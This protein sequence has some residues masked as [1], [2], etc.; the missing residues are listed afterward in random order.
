M[1]NSIYKIILGASASLLLC[2]L[3]VGIFQIEPG[4]GPF[5]IGALVCLAF[6]IRGF[7]ATKQFAFTAWILTVVAAAM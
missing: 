6:G 7:K 5:L 2:A 4:T 3:F 1:N